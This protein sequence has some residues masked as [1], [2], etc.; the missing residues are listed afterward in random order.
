[1]RVGAMACDPPAINIPASL[2]DCTALFSVR[3]AHVS[4][5]YTRMSYF[6]V[7]TLFRLMEQLHSNYN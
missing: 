5:L 4:R 1:M 6:E 2:R 7:A 3:A